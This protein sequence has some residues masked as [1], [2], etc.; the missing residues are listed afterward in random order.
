MM[1]NIFG[2]LLNRLGVNHQCGRRTDG[3][4]YDIACVER[5]AL[6]MLFIRMSQNSGSF[7]DLHRRQ[8]KTHSWHQSCRSV[9]SRSLTAWHSV[10][11]SRQRHV[12]FLAVQRPS[13][14]RSTVKL[15]HMCHLQRSL[16]APHFITIGSH[17]WLWCPIKM[18]VMAGQQFQRMSQLRSVYD[19]KPRVW[20]NS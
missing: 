6:K 4:S 2:D 1:H 11:L 5:L 10:S 17:L 9:I 14:H 3:K 16:C 19:N 12:H 13:L 20:I 8:T 7:H 18:Q 15:V